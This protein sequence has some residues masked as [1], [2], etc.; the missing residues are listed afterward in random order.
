M[1]EQLHWA[2]LLSCFPATLRWTR[3]RDVPQNR[4]QPHSR[5]TTL[6]GRP[7]NVCLECD[8]SPWFSQRKNKISPEDNQQ[9]MIKSYGPN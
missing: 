7:Q 1:A 4:V 3:H 5:H 6:R 2:A 9:L 8:L